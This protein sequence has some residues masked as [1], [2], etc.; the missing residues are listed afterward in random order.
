[1]SYVTCHMSCVT[2]YLACVTCHISQFWADP[3]KARGC[4]TKPLSL[5]HYLIHLL[6]NPSVKISLRRRHALMVGDGAF[7]HKTRPRWSVPISW[8]LIGL[9][10]WFLGHFK[11][12][13]PS[14]FGSIFFSYISVLVTFQFWWH[15]SLVFFF[16]LSDKM[17]EL[18]VGGSVINRA[19]LV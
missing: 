10:F 19:Y 4:S 3:G 1:M 7:S 14:S 8:I 16:F 9:R 18:A 2:C 5:I 6:S 15:C 17:V 11:I 12:L 13:W